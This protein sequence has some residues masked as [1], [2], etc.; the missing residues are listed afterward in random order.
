MF[1][2][3]LTVG[4][5][6]PLALS[7]CFVSRV[8]PEKPELPLPV[9]LPQQADQ[10]VQL[11]DPWWTIFRDPTLDRLVDEAIAHNPDI[12]VAAARVAEAR[13]GLRIVNADRVPNLDIEADA[14]R[15]KDS[16]FVIGR[17]IPCRAPSVMC[18]ISGAATSALPSPPARSC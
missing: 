3:L 5:L 1:S 12:A 8:D 10:S 6:L 15:S 16:A 11:P 18:W 14:T 13:A 4:V 17:S 2:R 9:A 7:G